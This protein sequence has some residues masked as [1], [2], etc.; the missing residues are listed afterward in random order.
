MK[1]LFPVLLAAAVAAG[2]GG[3]AK[4]GPAT[5][6]APG[7]PAPGGDRGTEGGPTIVMP[8]DSPRVVVEAEAAEKLVVPFQ[9][10][11]DADASGGKALTLPSKG[12]A[13]QHLHIAEEGTPERTA[14]SAELALTIEKEGTYYLWIRRW[15]CCSCGDSFNLE[16]DG[17]KAFAFGN[18]GT[19]FRRWVWMEHKDAD[20]PAKFKLAA[21]PHKLVFKNRGESG[22]RIDQVLFATDPKFVPQGRETPSAG[23]AAQAPA[24]GP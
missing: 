14:G 8:S 19:T 11:A 13:G 24:G 23:A 15:W 22:F 6:G 18:D 9:V 10:M 20:G 4:P 3:G 5:P 12:C 16:L 2:C 21:G 17:G 1:W 7:S